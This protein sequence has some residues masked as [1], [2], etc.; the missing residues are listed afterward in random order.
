MSDLPLATSHSDIHEA[1]S[2]LYPLLRAAL[3][4]LLLLLGLNLW[5][6]R[7]STSFASPKSLL[8][9]KDGNHVQARCVTPSVV[10]G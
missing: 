4:D 10:R 2:V 7:I 5:R 9:V 1:A 3:G 6:R 8:P